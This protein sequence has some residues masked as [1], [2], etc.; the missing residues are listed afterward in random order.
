MSSLAHGG[1]TPLI[2]TSASGTCP[3]SPLI[4]P[5]RKRR[6]SSASIVSSNGRTGSTTV[7]PPPPPPP[8]IQQHGGANGIRPLG[9]AP[10]SSSILNTN[11][12]WTS[13]SPV[14]SA[15]LLSPS[16][17]PTSNRP[18]WEIEDSIKGPLYRRNPEFKPPTSR[19]RSTS[20]SPAT[21][22]RS[23]SSCDSVPSNT[24]LRQRSNSSKSEQSISTSYHAQV[25]RSDGLPVLSVEDIP[26]TPI[27]IDALEKATR[28]TWDGHE[29]AD[30]SLAPPVPPVNSCM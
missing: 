18:S 28:A 8:S 6:R 25:L 16:L 17:S 10:S 11:Y 14:L 24:S 22:R 13:S 23:S 26:L 5:C 3:S 30:P 20:P 15:Y 2:A 12:E 27:E 19:S 9:Q 1:E 21:S 29:S 7:Q 4:G